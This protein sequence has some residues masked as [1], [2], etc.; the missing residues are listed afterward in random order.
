MWFWDLGISP[1]VCGKPLEPQDSWCPTLDLDW[2]SLILKAEI[3][4]EMP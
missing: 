4:L 3:P 1:E 2:G